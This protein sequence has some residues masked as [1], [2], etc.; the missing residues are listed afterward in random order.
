M[1]PRSKGRWRRNA[2][3]L[4]KLSALCSKGGS[5]HPRFLVLARRALGL[6]EDA[7]L[8]ANEEHVVEV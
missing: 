7:L 4:G 1:R 3:K 2:G 8:E 5:V 6:D